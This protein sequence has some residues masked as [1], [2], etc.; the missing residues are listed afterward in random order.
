MTYQSLVLILASEVGTLEPEW[1][2]K[3][4]LDVIGDFMAAFP[5]RTASHLRGQ[6]LQEADLVAGSRIHEEEDGIQ[7]LPTT[8]S[9]AMKQLDFD[10]HGHRH[11]VLCKL[12]KQRTESQKIGFSTG[13][14]LRTDCKI[15]FLQERRHGES[16]R[17]SASRQ[18]HCSYGWKNLAHSRNAVCHCWDPSSC[19]N[20]QEN[21]VQKC[22]MWT[23][24]QYSS[25]R[26]STR[27]T[28]G[29]GWSFCCGWWC[30]F[31]G[32]SDTQ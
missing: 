26:T 19:C 8:G 7:A 3:H 28:V 14:T 29:V 20:W 12:C 11:N 18:S 22:P 2:R 13:G 32:Y 30:S 25:S 27:T 9:S 15:P 5:T 17:V 31:D 6:L 16:I 4:L 1:I 24:K 21:W 10:V 23:N